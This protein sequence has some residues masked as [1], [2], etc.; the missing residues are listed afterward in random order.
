MTEKKLSVNDFTPPNL[1][2]K[3]K[4]A[5]GR[6]TAYIFTDSICLALWTAYANGRPLLLRGDPGT[7]KSE[8]AYAIAVHLGWPML[9]KII[10]G[11]TEFDEL[12]FH[13]DAV[14][15]LADAQL[16]ACRH[17]E[18]DLQN[19]EKKLAAANY[20][21]PGPLWWAF[22]WQ[23]AK[24]D[25]TGKARPAA[26]VPPVPDNWQPGQGCVLLIDEID[27]ADPDLPNSLLETFGNQ[28]FAVPLLSGHE[29]CANQPVLTII[30]TNEERDLP[31][32]FLRRCLVL[33]LEMETDE[34]TRLE[35]MAERGKLHFSDDIEETVY[36]YAAELVW[37]QRQQAEE[38][39]LY[40]PG[41]A[42]YLDLLNALCHAPVNEQRTVL[43]SI[44]D[45]AL[46]KG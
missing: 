4:D 20:I 21:S 32:A 8:L 10:Q 7:G 46:K 42:E 19:A 12:H 41:L 33:T 11:N 44:A 16:C 17:T 31:Q 26:V 6:E 43:D 15:R 5:S 29:V 1:R 27:K 30:T 9:K 22:N 28:R 45:F 39:N 24:E 37:K 2:V 38:L 23:D 40:Q 35:W 18:Q 25:D 14:K 13:Y 34:N 36:L 3:K